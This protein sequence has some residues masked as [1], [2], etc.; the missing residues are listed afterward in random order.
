M[1]FLENWIDLLANHIWEILEEWRFLL[2]KVSYC[3]WMRTVMQPKKL[4]MWCSE[5][6]ENCKLRGCLIL[7]TWLIIFPIHLCGQIIWCL[8]LTTWLILSIHLSG[9][10][11]W[12]LVQ[13]TW[14]LVLPSAYEVERDW[15][16]NTARFA[17][18]RRNK[19]DCTVSIP[20]CFASKGYDT[21]QAIWKP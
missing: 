10:M 14:L 19:G 12:W 8:I 15:T 6:W 16:I 4:R 17:N 5:I 13:T 2:T 7:T 9:L 20:M 3:G 21:I 1:I 18:Q 11:N